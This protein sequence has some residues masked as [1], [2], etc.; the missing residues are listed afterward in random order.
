M[1]ARPAPASSPATAAAVPAHSRA[2]DRLLLVKHLAV[3]A[4]CVTLP[5]DKAAHD[6][7]RC[8]Y[9]GQSRLTR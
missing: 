2:S 6:A 1:H 5:S 3:L 4:F 7:R 9:D 8:S